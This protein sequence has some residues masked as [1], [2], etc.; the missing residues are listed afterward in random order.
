MLKLATQE[1]SQGEH[2]GKVT[3]DVELEREDT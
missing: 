1:V 3:N 2:A